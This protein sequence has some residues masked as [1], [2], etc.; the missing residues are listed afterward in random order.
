MSESVQRTVFTRLWQHRARLD[1]DTGEIELADVD[2]AKLT[3]T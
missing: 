1:H 2:R 3:V